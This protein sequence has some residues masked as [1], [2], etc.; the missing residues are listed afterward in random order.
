MQHESDQRKWEMDR[1]FSS[2]FL[3]VYLDESV[4]LIVTFVEF[5][6]PPPGP[7]TEASNMCMY[8]S[9]EPL[10]SGWWALKF[11]PIQLHEKGRTQEIIQE[12]LQVLLSEKKGIRKSSRNHRANRGPPELESYES[13]MKERRTSGAKGQ[14]EE[15]SHGLHVRLLARSA[16]AAR[17]ARPRVGPK[18]EK[19][20]LI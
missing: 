17:G 7:Q 10:K 8:F 20:E 18:A 3:R 9:R 4:D 19:G 16:R 1:S 6:F 2:S 11:I 12:P 14:G 13:F 5:H 15:R